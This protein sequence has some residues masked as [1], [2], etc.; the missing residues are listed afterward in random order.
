MTS[1]ERA[2]S[3]CQWINEHSATHRVLNCKGDMG[4]AR[5]DIWYITQIGTADGR[6]SNDAQLVTFA[7]SQGWKG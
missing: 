2:L 5:K 7:K 3:A 4:E 6:Y 1:Y